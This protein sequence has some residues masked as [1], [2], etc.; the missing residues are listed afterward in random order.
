MMYF[1]F[2]I[3]HHDV[4]ALLVDT[5]FADADI[6]HGGLFWAGLIISVFTAGT[7][8]DNILQFVLRLFMFAAPVV[9]PIS[10]VPEKY[11]FLFWLNPLTP[12]IETCRAAFFSP[13]IVHPE[14]LLISG[15]AFR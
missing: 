7:R 13:H 8:L 1:Y 2:M 11:K 12:V 9:Y 10:I 5:D 6:D 4:S 15:L 3:A 14:Y